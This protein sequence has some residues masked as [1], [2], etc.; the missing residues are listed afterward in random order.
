MRSMLAI[1]ILCLLAIPV[2]G[3]C[4]DEEELPPEWT[5]DDDEDI[6]NWGGMNN[7]EALE[8]DDVKDQK[9]E[10]RSVLLT[11]STGVD[12][13]VF[14]DGAWGGFIADVLPFDGGEYDTIYIGV[15][16][17]VSDT[18]QIYYISDVDGNYAEAQSQNFQVN[19]TGKFEDLEF[20]METGGWQDRMITGFRLDPGVA[21]GVEAEI[22]YISLRGIPADAADQAVEYNGKLAAT[23][24]DIKR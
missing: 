23:W 1:A 3:I 12:P 20:E 7:L 10:I 22:D 6:R 9:G 13:Y 15:R 24:G 5:F 19:A 14:P 21:A 17:N 16:V 8:L 18:W 4:Q 2:I 11:V